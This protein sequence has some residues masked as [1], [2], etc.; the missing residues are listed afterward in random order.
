MTTYTYW[1]NLETVQ[2][3]ARCLES[4]IRLA[5]AHARVRLS[6]KVDNRDCIAVLELLS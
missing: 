1:S 6:S 2:V 3:T 4:L 5:T